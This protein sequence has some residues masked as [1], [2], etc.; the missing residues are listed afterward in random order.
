MADDAAAKDSQKAS[1]F[2]RLG[3]EAAIR[4]IVERFYDV[5]ETDPAAA[6]IRAMHAADLSVMRS[7]LADWM[8]GALGG[9]PLYAQRPDRGCMGS[10]HKAFPIGEEDVE[11]WMYCLR[12]AWADENVDLGLR[13]LLDT[14]FK[15]MATM[16]R[17]R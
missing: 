5:M 8:I 12:K 16:L 17:S 7:K 14:P 9:P 15:E 6:R 13:E 11:E 4:R 10:V 2:E 3:G 1:P